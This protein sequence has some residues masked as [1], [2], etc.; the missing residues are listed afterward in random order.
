MR[1]FSISSSRCVAREL[2]EA[3]AVLVALR[4]HESSEQTT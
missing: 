4:R 2:S 3:L 1:R